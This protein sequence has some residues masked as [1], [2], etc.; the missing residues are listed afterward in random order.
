LHFSQRLPTS[1]GPGISNGS[2]EFRPEGDYS[3][4]PVGG[5]AA[6]ASQR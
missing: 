4:P 3:G 5:R 6:G 1:S 2:P